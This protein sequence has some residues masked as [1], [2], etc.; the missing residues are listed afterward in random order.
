MKLSDAKRLVKNYP[1]FPKEGIQFKDI[2][3]VLENPEAFKALTRSAKQKISALEFNKIV[4]IDARG[5]IFGSVLA[6]VM[7]KGFIMCRKPGKLPGSLHRASFAYEYAETELGIQAERFSPKDNVL[8]IDDVLA[9]GGTAK[10]AGK[11]VLNAGAN[12]A[13]FLFIVN[14]PFLKGIEKLEKTFPGV[15]VYFVLSY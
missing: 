14:L 10:A 2:S 6:H 13:G 15:P 7:H 12:L 11:I 5:F 9:T 3:P 1:D 4:G 8:I